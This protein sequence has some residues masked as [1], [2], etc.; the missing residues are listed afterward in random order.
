MFRYRHREV[1]QEEDEIPWGRVT[2]AFL[3]MLAIAGVLIVWAWTAMES[4]ESALRPSRVFPERSLGP[5]REVGMV[6]QELFGG[7][8]VGQDLFDAQRGELERFGVVD[9]E[10]GI[11]SI[12]IDDAIE[13]VVKEHA[14]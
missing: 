14:R 6:Q 1:R 8:R 13:L 12:P 11:V 3:A 10:R 7:V 9:R 4:G 2:L 5:R